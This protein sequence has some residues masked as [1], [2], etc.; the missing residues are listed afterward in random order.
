MNQLVEGLREL[1]KPIVKEIVKETIHECDSTNISNPEKLLSVHAAAKEFGIHD[2]WLRRAMN[3][4]ELSYYT[5]TDNRTYVKRG[6]VARYL[7][8]LRVKTN[9]EIQD[10]SFLKK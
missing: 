9:D 6:D 8:S 3:E 2:N 5:P 1:I 10:Y 4:G 7:D